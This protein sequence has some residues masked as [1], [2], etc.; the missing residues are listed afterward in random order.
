MI[1]RVATEISADRLFDYAVPAELEERLRVGQRVSVPFGGRTVDAYV[2]EI[3]ADAS[4]TGAG[5]SR[6]EQPELFAPSDLAPPASGLRS[7]LALEDEVPYLSPPLIAL[8]RWMA[9]YYC[10]PFEATLRCALPAAVRNSDMR[11]KEQLFVSPVEG[12]FQLTPR[13]AE[14]HDGLRRVGGGWLH[15]LTREFS[16]TPQILRALAEKGAA[17]IEKRR[18]RRD[19]LANRK[20]LPSRP[21]PL[22]DEQAA[23]L[24]Q[25]FALMDGL[26]ES[27]A[28]IGGRRSE[29][30]VEH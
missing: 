26:N 19:P 9:D 29:V 3:A 25:I 18:M 17:A 24:E 23:A 2:V 13:Q 10:A 11:A 14:L 22:M 5:P 28:E 30:G 4:R 6:Q 27:G 8:A 20:I 12:T 7:V 15:A 1:V 21:M 16:C